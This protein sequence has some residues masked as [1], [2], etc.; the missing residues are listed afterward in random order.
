MGLATARVMGMA[1]GI[2]VTGVCSLDAVA[3]GAGRLGLSEPEFLVAIDARRGEV[4]WARYRISAGNG[5]PIR[6]GSPQVGPADQIGFSGLPVAGR[7]A[8]LYPDVLGQ[9]LPPL[10]PGA[11]DLARL[12][13]AGEPYLNEPEPL[14]LRRPDAQ[15][16]GARKRVR[17]AR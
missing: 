11:A 4:Y 1:L 13:V 2:P 3:A 14:Y 9:P 15:V 16:P 17:P 6:Q 5:L 7:G 10:D 12:A 8:L